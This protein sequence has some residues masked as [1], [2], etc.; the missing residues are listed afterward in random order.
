M[1][2]GMTAAMRMRIAADRFRGG[3]TKP[4]CA[5]TIVTVGR[6]ADAI[7]NKET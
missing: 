1:G 2:S 5:C 3:L 4:R 7:L 6:R